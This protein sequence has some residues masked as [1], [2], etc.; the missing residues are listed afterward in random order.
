MVIGSVDHALIFVLI[1]QLDLIAL[2]IQNTDIQT[3]SLQFLNQNLKGLRYAGL[4]NIGTLDDCFVGLDTAGH[5]VGLDGQDLLQSVS[6]AVSFQRPNFHFAET[7]TAELGLAA[8]RLL[9]NQCVRTGGTGMDL[10]VDQMMQL[11]VVGIANGNQ[12]I[13]RLAGTAI[14][15]N[16]LA[17]LT[18]TSQL[19]GLTDVLLVCAVKYGGGNIPTQC[20]CSVAQVDFQNLTNVH[21]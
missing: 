11:Q 12:V 20:S 19:Q 7:L 10:V 4:G 5:I 2:L 13:E 3:Q 18:Q 21:T 14:V 6:S 15:Q 17:V 9:G 16:G 8:Q 1:A